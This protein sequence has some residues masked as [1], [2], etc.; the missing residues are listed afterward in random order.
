MA[1]AKLDD[2]L[3]GH[4]KIK[5]AWR[6]SRPA[7]GLHLLAMSYCAAY[8]TE[9][10]VPRDFVEEKL[11][12][13][14]ERVTALSALTTVPAM[15]RSALWNETDGGWQIHDWAEYNGDAE[16]RQRLRAAKSKAG[17]AGAA[18][19][20]GR[21]HADSRPMA[22]ANGESIAPSPSPIPI[23]SSSRGG[24][25]GGGRSA[26]PSIDQ[27]SLPDGFPSQL[28]E[29][30]E[31]ILAKIRITQE[32]VSPRSEPATLYRIGLS[33]KASPDVDHAALFDRFHFNATGPEGKRR[34]NGNETDVVGLWMVYCQNAQ[35][36]ARGKQDGSS[37]SFQSRDEF[38]RSFKGAA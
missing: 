18:A 2:Q 12:D 29:R 21:R 15:A 27:N 28:A 26:S 7:V 34:R 14:T 3:H 31:E 33:L 32:Q 5:A 36:R 38:L 22:G 19:R 8:G 16:T 6:A 11:P 10:F 1:W 13:A 24:G 23:P 4:P 17:R 30:A 20:W 9:G 37:S 35:R 25:P